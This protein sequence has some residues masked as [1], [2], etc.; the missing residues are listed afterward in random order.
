LPL[1]CTSGMIKAILPGTGNL[2][3]FRE[4]RRCRPG[5]LF[6]PGQKKMIAVKVKGVGLDQEQNPLLLLMDQEETIILPIGIGLGEA[7]IISLRLD[8]FV[9]PRPLTHDLIVSLCQKLDAT[10]RKIVVNDIREGTYYAQ[11]FLEKDNQEIIVDSRPSDGVALALTS[12]TPLFITE[13]VAEHSLPFGEVLKENFEE[14]FGEDD[15]NVL[16]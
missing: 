7:Q 9:L 5:F 3:D 14:F 16:H 15:E 2:E 8:G 10:I 11:I 4:E 6:E 13:K 12:G 1:V